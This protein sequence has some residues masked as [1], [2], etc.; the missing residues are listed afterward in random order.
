MANNYTFLDSNSSVQTAASSVVSGAHQPLVQITSFLSAV[1]TTPSGNQSV[2]GTV[3]IGTMPGS[4]ASYPLG[5]IVTSIMSTVPSSVLVGA[6]IFGQLPAGTAPIGSVATLQGTNPW[7]MTGS[8]QGFPANQN[9][10][11]SVVAF[12][13]SG[14]VA[15]IQ[16]GTWSPSAIG[17]LRRNDALASTL[18]AD[19]TYGPGTRDSAGRIINKPFAA[20]ESRVEGYASTVSTSVTTLVAAAGAGLKNYITDVLVANTGAAT[21]LITFKD[22]LGSILGYTI[23]P[24]ASGSNVPGMTTPFVTQANASFDF[25]NAT[26]TSVLYMTVKGFKAP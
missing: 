18:G 10:S 8:V 1:P 5:T 21:T 2:S 22:G 24:T 9:V 17:Y 7:I 19:L 11:G 13:S 6:S 23:A 20:E 14:S 3:N 4:V 12:V 15:A 25:V 26:A 16:A